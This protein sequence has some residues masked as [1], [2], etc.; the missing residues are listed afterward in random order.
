MTAFEQAWG[1]AKMPLVRDSVKEHEDGVFSATFQDRDDP[2]K[3]LRMRAD[4]GANAEWPH[5]L[6]PGVYDDEGYRLSGGA[7]EHRDNS[8]YP[9]AVRTKKGHERKGYMTA[10]IDFMNEIARG[11]GESPIH[12]YAGNLSG[13]FAPLWAKHLGLPYEEGKYQDAHTQFQIDHKGKKLEWPE[14][15]VYE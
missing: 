2:D 15:G 7:F 14:E 13:D 11:R 8:W 5:R 4:G 3:Q 9:H 1:V 10:I 6:Y 12:T